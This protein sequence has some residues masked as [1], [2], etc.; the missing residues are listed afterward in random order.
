V[1][2]PSEAL[3]VANRMPSCA[4]QEVLQMLT[5]QAQHPF[6]NWIRAV[7]LE[8][9]LVSQCSKDL[10]LFSRASL[11]R[12]ASGLVAIFLGYCSPMLIMVAPTASTA[13]TR[14]GCHRG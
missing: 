8:V 12:F 4:T 5:K 6:F 13:K 11:I 1:I 14:F 7:F 3:A 9:F 2:D 10:H